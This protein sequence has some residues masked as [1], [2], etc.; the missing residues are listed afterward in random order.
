MLWRLLL[1]LGRW[2]WLVWVLLIWI[3][4][5]VL[6]RRGRLVWLLVWLLLVLGLRL[7]RLWLLIWLLITLLEG[8]NLLL[9]LVPAAILVVCWRW[10]RVVEVFVI[11]RAW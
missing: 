1:R 10:G 9:R 11:H 6:L 8:L 3:V 7:V 5:L 2:C 4:L